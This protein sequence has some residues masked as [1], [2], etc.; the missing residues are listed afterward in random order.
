MCVCE[1][2]RCEGEE[3]EGGSRGG[4]LEMSGAEEARKGSG[5]RLARKE[6]NKGRKVRN[7]RVQ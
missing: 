6:K 3:G 1:R 7:T 2:G 4:R 5:R